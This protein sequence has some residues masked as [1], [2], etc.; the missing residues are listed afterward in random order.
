MA[1]AA[2]DLLTPPPAITGDEIQISP[3]ELNAFNPD[4]TDAAE[5]AEAATDAYADAAHA[6]EYKGEKKKKGLPQL[7]PTYYPSQLFWLVFIF[8][9]MYLFFSKKILP[10]MSNTIKGRRMHIQEDLDTAASLKEEAEKIHEAYDNILKDARDKSSSSYT[11]IENDIKKLTTKKV[12]GFQLRASRQI[13][14]TE[15]AIENAKGAAMDEMHDIAAETA[16]IA[17]EK[18]IGVSTDLK[19]AQTVVKSIDKKAA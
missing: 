4:A 5:H 18:I 2:E 3:T 8:V 13:K 14:E 6:D 10:E 11:K 17:A 12:E 7:D 19:K 9:S 16:R 15:E 1:V